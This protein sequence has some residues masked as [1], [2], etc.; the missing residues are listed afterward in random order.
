MSTWL[1]PR[2]SEFTKLEDN[3]GQVNTLF[4][5]LVVFLGEANDTDIDCLFGLLDRFLIDFDK[6]HKDIVRR[7]EI[8]LKATQA[9]LG[10]PKKD[11]N[12]ME[13]VLGE[14]VSGAAFARKQRQISMHT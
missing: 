3:L 5:E 2:Q 13:N 11:A 4:K 10:G 14:L 12:V 6:A 1:P 9:K 8:A 7:R